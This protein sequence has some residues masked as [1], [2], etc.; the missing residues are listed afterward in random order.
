[1]PA[2]IEILS[3]VAEQE[4]VQASE[5][6][7]ALDITYEAA[8][9]GLLRAYRAGLAARSGLRGTEVFRYSL[10]DKGWERLQYLAVP[11]RGRGA[12]ASLTPSQR[13][14]LDMRMKKTYSGLYYCPICLYEAELT[15]ETSLKC[16]D[17][18]ER[19]WKGPLPEVEEGD[20]DDYEED[21][22]D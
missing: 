20:E 22:E 13:G 16:E 5:V 7:E 14:D 3:I 11:S 12:I 18:G 21:E 1:M 8:A 6:A 2:K 10:T 15:A 4:A 9:M 17:C 19:L